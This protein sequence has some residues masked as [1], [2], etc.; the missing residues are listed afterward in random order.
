MDELKQLLRSITSRLEAVAGELS[1]EEA[2]EVRQI[3]NLATKKIAGGTQAP[4]PRG[5]EFLY[6]L[7]G[8][9]PA[10]FANY[11]Q[12]FPDASM[13]QLAKQPQELDAVL[14]QLQRRIT[15]P[16]GQVIDG[17]PK[18]PLNSSNVYGYQYD[19]R[20]RMLRV[21]FNE[22]GVYE[23]DN[24]PPQIFKLFAQGAIPAKTNG[25]NRWGAWWRGKQPSS[26]ASLNQL[27]KKGGFNY[28]KLN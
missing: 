19:P 22:G 28:R 23:Y 1:E 27:I 16:Q 6:V 26:G 11:V 7:A 13:N 10:A 18:A 14:Q 15:L 8:G 24:V 17:I 21:R 2:R 12:Q 20:Q 9:N 5:A 4:I 3:I 25:R